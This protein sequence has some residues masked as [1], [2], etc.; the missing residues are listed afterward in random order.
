VAEAALLDPAR[1]VVSDFEVERSPLDML[2]ATC[3]GYPYFIQLYGHALW[4]VATTPHVG[5]E[6]VE[7]ALSLGRDEL[8]AEL[9]LG[10]WKRASERSKAYMVAMAALGDGPVGSG[11]V[12]AEFGG[13]R[14][15]ATIRDGLIDEG[16]VYSPARGQVAFTVPGF[17]DFI[18]RTQTDAQP[19][20]A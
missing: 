18:R 13:H 11:A 10:R 17:A 20:T 12:A 5:A 14:A 4:Q 6:Q 2:L 9:Y 1:A 8:E 16:L 15:A 19:S 7:A 3:D